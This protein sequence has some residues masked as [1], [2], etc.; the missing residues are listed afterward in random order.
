MDIT[1]EYHFSKEQFFEERRKHLHKKGL[2]AKRIYRSERSWSSLHKHSLEGLDEYLLLLGGVAFIFIIPSLTL[3]PEPIFIPILL[4]ISLIIKITVR[5]GKMWKERYS[6]LKEI[7]EKRLEK[8]WHQYKDFGK[9]FS[10]RLVE[11]STHTI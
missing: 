9:N 1:Q 8:E 2:S 5:R 6:Y 3:K 7:E 4:W 10:P 11:P